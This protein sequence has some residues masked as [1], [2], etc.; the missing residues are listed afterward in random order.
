MT[1][2]YPF[3]LT[4]KVFF[5]SSFAQNIEKLARLEKFISGAERQTSS[6]REVNIISKVK[7][8][9][10][11]EKN[12]LFEKIEDFRIITT[13]S[14][15]TPARAVSF[16]SI[17]SYFSSRLSSHHKLLKWIYCPWPEEETEAFLK[18][19]FGQHQQ[20]W[21][22][23]H[24]LQVSIGFTDEYNFWRHEAGQDIALLPHGK[25]TQI[26]L[27]ALPKIEKDNPLMWPLLVHEVA[28]EFNRRYEI[29][30]K[31]FKKLKDKLPRGKKSI[32]EIPKHERILKNWISEFSADLIALHLL[33]FSYI[34][35]LIYI[36]LSEDQE[37]L[38]QA[39]EDHPPSAMRVEYLTNELETDFHLRR[40]GLLNSVVEMFNYRL[41][42]DSYR[43]H[44]I[45]ESSDK[46]QCKSFFCF[47][48]S[49]RSTMLMIFNEVKSVLKEEDLLAYIVTDETY[50]ICK[51]LTQRLVSGISISSKPLK[52][53]HD[54]IDEIR[55][56]IKRGHEEL[57]TKNKLY[58]FFNE[59]PSSLNEIVTA[60]WIFKVENQTKFFNEYFFND[61][62]SIEKRYEQYVTKLFRNDG[63]LTESIRKSIVH[64][65]YTPS[66][67]NSKASL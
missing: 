24:N 29:K 67:I 31:V 56:I 27:I 16:L 57:D 1:D 51:E 9:L 21:S 44:K 39:S 8:A 50:D 34:C 38:H 18:T 60:G 10:N 62:L 26:P 32:L 35:P 11:E 25:V 42:I 41:N 17:L 54:K 19:V 30:K 7:G 37:N 61:E 40:T 65:F 4:T 49:F 58:D 14:N 5:D 63:L 59:I 3:L 48:D 46:E 43:R 66:E 45:E 28:H 52:Q 13:K 55:D 36:L 22:T 23:F 47:E 12:Y 53:G 64:S 6:D 20:C 15:L 2:D 33:G